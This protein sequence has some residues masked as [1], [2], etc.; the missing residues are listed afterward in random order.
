[1]SISSS[2]NFPAQLA[3]QLRFLD[4]SCCAFDE[5]D[6]DEAVRIATTIRTI[7][8]QT[9]HSTSLLR[10]LGAEE[11]RLLS[12]AYKPPIQ[13]GTYVITAPIFLAFVRMGASDMSHE[14]NLGQTP[15]RLV[16]V[17]EW[18]TEQL[19]ELGQGVVVRRRDIALV[20]ANRDGGAHVDSELTPE[21]ERLGEN[22]RLISWSM[23]KNGTRVEL[24]SPNLHYVALRTMGWEVLNSPELRELAGTNLVGLPRSNARAHSQGP[25]GGLPPPPPIATK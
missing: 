23:T 3:I 22:G 11:I 8:H 10:H 15:V 1:M 9:S 16:S 19:A 5:G 20:A 21:Y 18:W 4:R 13:P 14:P 12:M 17:S 25:S 6:E 24:P 2:R 7:V